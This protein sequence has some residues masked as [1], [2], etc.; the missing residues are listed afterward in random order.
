MKYDLREVILWGRSLGASTIIQYIKETEGAGVQLVILDSP[1]YILRESVAF[2]V[3]NRFGLSPIISNIACKLIQSKIKQ[4]TH[5]DVLGITLEQDLDSFK[6]PVILMASHQDEIV[7]FSHINTIFQRITEKR[8]ILLMTERKHNESREDHI[9]AEALDYVVYYLKIGRN[10]N[11]KRILQVLVQDRSQE[12]LFSL[13]HTIVPR[14]ERV[15]TEK[16]I[17]PYQNQRSHSHNN[18]MR[19]HFKNSFR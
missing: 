11:K 10:M 8:K 18:L 17:V 5:H 15:Q 2:F 12:N 6:C 7:P 1:F 3:K 4:V 16:V 19:A 9:I 13:K 14:M